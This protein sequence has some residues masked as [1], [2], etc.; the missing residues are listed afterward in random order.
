MKQVFRTIS[1]FSGSGGLDLGLIKTG[2]FKICLANDIDPDACETYRQNIGDHIVCGDIRNLTDPPSAD[3]MVGGPP[4]QGFSLGNPK[5]AFDDPRNWLFKEYARLLEQVK[6]KL[7]LMENVSGL[8]TL[9]NGKVFELIK[10]GFASCGYHIYDKLLNAMHYGVP[11]SRNRVIIVGVRKDV[12]HPFTFPE[13]AVHPPLF[14]EYKTV[15]DAILTRSIS[16]DDPNHSIGK[17]TPL[18]AERLSHIPAGGS[19]QDCPKELWNGSDVKR[20]MRRLHPDKPSYT[21]VHNNCDHYYHP[22]EGRR[23]TIREM[24][25][26]QTYPQDFVFSG[27][28]SEQSRQVGNSVPVE[29]ARHL[30]LS[31][32]SF[33]DRYF[34][35]M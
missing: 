6:P 27:S 32:A 17:L 15:R 26:I 23:I 34:S 1:L 35:R 22:T 3:V 11:Q 14:G 8:L 19:M 16:S 29:F 30:G 24:A 9:E 5:R 2:R 7:F 13:P 4:C 12:H 20:A 25:L 33:A 31:L 28:K 10:S 21:I 18:N